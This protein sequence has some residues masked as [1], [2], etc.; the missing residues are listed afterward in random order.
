MRNILRPDPSIIKRQHKSFMATVDQY[1]QTELHLEVFGAVR[2]MQ[3][4]ATF[5]SAAEMILRT[6]HPFA[7]Q[8]HSNPRVPPQ[9]AQHS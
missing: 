2:D 7:L 9:K 4:N 6:A 5:R 8:P 1:L 3:N